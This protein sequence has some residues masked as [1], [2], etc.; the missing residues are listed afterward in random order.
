MT[1]SDGHSNFGLLLKIHERKPKM[2]I[3]ILKIFSS[4]FDHAPIHL[5]RM[6]D[7]HS[8]ILSLHLSLYNF[9]IGF[10]LYISLTIDTY[11]LR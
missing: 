11:L 4:N 8:P 3:K 1:E 10:N 7:I 6:F 9:R 5:K 2:K